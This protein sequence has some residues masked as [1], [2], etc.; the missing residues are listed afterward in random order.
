MTIFIALDRVLI[1]PKSV[2]NFLISPQ[3]PI[4][5]ILTRTASQ[6][7]SMQGWPH[8]AVPVFTIFPRKKNL[9]FHANCLLHVNE[10][11]MNQFAWNIKKISE[12]TQEMPQ[13]WSTAFPKC[14]KKERWGTNN[15]KTNPTYETIEQK[16]TTTQG[17]LGM[18]LI[19]VL[20][21]KLRCHTHFYFSAN[22][23]TWSGLLL[24]HI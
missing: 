2:D 24:S 11:D 16:R 20:L 14:Q 21:N 22:Q 8:F 12:D 4:L 7:L 19:L 17:H 5:W 3:K 13:L 18:V 1:V 10:H 6:R 9:T 15:D 23:I